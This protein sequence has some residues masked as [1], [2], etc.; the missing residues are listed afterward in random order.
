MLRHWFANPWAF[1]LLSLMP[2]LSL[3]G[4]FALRRRRR[5]LSQ[6]GNLLMLEVL[7]APRRG[8]RFVRSLAFSLAMTLLAVGVAGPQWGRDWSQT[9]APGRDL[10]VVLDL[11]RSMFAEQPSRLDRA[12]AALLD[13]VATLKQRGGHRVGLVVFAGRAKVVCPLTHD[14]DH[15]KEIAEALDGDHLPPDLAVTDD[16]GSGTRIGAGLRAAV[17]L[18]DSR[19][20]GYQDILLL[21]DGDD[22]ARDGEW[23]LPAAEAR[24][25]EIPV[26]AVGLGD[27]DRAW[28]I[29]LGEGRVLEHDG[30]PVLT[31]LEEEPLQEISHI[32]EGVYTPAHT[33]A[34][35]LGKLF[36]ERV[37]PRPVREDSDDALPLYEQRYPWFLGAALLL[38]T[39]DMALGKRTRGNRAVVAPPDKETEV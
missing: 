27:P 6:L 8:A 2:L 1:S 20:R 14:Y 4:F 38:L 16:D 33:K 23:R 32:T 18:H 36:R 5:A 11:S 3:L 26:H 29:P 39:G 13:L 24:A 31:R 15:F 7:I 10:V 37:E 34:L 21:S 12:R 25:K 30:K 17:E 35:P 22:P 19:H 9:V 28:P